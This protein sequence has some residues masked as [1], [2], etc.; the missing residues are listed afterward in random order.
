MYSISRTDVYLNV[1]QKEQRIEGQV[2][3][4]VWSFR[5]TEH[6]RIEEKLRASKAFQV[7]YGRSQ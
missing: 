7:G 3:G 5:E 1:I 6:K 4:R 2:S